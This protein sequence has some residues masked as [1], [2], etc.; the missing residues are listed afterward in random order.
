MVAITH[1]W[2]HYNIVLLIAGG[3]EIQNLA[4]VGS[5]I[6]D[7]RTLYNYKLRIDHSLENVLDVKH[8]MM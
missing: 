8:P 7:E 6:W 3:T 1:T 4:A 2:A 5:N